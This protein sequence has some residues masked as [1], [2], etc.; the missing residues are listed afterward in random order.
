MTKPATNIQL[1]AQIVDLSVHSK[2]LTSEDKDFT[3]FFGVIENCH[4]YFY[5]KGGYLDENQSQPFI[6]KPLIRPV[7]NP[8][9]KFHQAKDMG[10]VSGGRFL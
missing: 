7:V 9:L 4:S 8:N 1:E 2:N 3:D 5:R 6:R 10:S